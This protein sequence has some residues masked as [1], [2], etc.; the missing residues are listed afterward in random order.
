MQFRG[1]GER[2]AR[3]RKS[4]L[5]PDGSETLQPSWRNHRVRGRERGGAGTTTEARVTTAREATTAEQLIDDLDDE[6]DE[7]EAEAAAT[8]ATTARA[9]TYDNDN[10]TNINDDIIIRESPN[11]HPC[12]SR[13]YLR[14]KN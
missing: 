13:E 11:S 12:R 4:S 3:G 9:A 6:D 10:N 2:F 7:E 8:T 1:P 14:K 5:Y